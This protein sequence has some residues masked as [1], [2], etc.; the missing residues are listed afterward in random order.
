MHTRY[1]N[2]CIL[3]MALLLQSFYR[4]DS[5]LSHGAHHEVHRPDTPC[6]RQARRSV[7]YSTVHRYRTLL[8]ITLL[9]T[10]I[11]G[12]GW[13]YFNSCHSVTLVYKTCVRVERK[14]GLF[15]LYRVSLQRENWACLKFDVF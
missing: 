10:L 4:S 11:L 3:T 12:Y 1:C 5:S 13:I 8:D 9:L 14:P 2:V 6:L 15:Q 7:K